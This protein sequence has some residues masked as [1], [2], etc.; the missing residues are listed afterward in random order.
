MA[1][2]MRMDWKGVT[3]EQYER[4]RELVQWETN[5]P[6]GGLSHVAAFDDDGLHVNDTW[7]SA[8]EFDAFVADRLM[9][10]VAEAGITTQPEITVIEAHAIYI[11]GVTH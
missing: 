7:S 1:I 8:A 2:L 5:Q 3:P 4:V 10:G 11:P 9:A 6:P